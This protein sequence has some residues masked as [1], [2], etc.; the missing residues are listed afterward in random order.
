MVQ[1]ITVDGDEVVDATI[2]G[3]AV[4]EITVDGV[5]SWAA[6]VGLDGLTVT[7]Q[8]GSYTA[9]NK[10][11][12]VSNG[13]TITLPS[14][15][16]DGI[17]MI[18]KVATQPELTGTVDGISE[19]YIS[20]DE[21]AVFVSDGNEWYSVDRNQISAIPDN[22]VDNFEEVQYEDRGKS[23]SDFYTGSLSEASRVENAATAFHGDYYLELNT[24]AS[25][26]GIFSYDGDGLN[27]Y[28]KDGETYRM[29]TNPQGQDSGIYWG[30]ESGAT[31]NGTSTNAY[32]AT[33]RSQRDKVFVTSGDGSSATTLGTFSTSA[34]SK[35]EWYEIE[36]QRG[37][38]MTITVFDDSGTNV[39]SGTFNNSDHTAANGIGWAANHDNGKTTTYH[40][41]GRV[42]A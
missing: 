15:V 26:T 8:D 30:V 29:S 33:I 39:G 22:T 37:D 35:F 34:L 16:Q 13:G 27:R 21:S 1:T 6:E 18:T 31:F 20:G 10:D 14:P 40:D 4:E 11:H 2:D 32:R 42:V 24:T 17:V 25:D 41:F 5:L 36:V 3:T 9:N 38:T 28:P 7:R 19:P 12:V 23:L